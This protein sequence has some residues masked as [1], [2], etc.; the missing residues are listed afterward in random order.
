MAAITGQSFNFR[1]YRKLNEWFFLETTD[2]M[3]SRLYM[4]SHQ[5]F[6]I[7]CGLEIQDGHHLTGGFH[8]HVYVL[9]IFQLFFTS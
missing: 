2:L 4:N 1:P 5:N 7:L 3:E 6:I 8:H 9:Y